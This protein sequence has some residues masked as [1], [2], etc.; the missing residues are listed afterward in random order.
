[1]SKCPIAFNFPLNMSAANVMLL[2]WSMQSR[3]AALLGTS[4]VFDEAC[5]NI[6]E[7]FSSPAPPRVSSVASIGSAT[8]ASDRDAQCQ[9]SNA[10]SRLS[11]RDFDAAKATVCSANLSLVSPASVSSIPS[12]SHLFHAEFSNLSKEDAALEESAAKRRKSST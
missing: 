3:L 10:S 5:R 8:P 11:C 7:P 2:C 6:L 12:N 9:S 1:M 4:D